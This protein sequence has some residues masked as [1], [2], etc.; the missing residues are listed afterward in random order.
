MK[1]STLSRLV[2]HSYVFMRE[3]HDWHSCEVSVLSIKGVKITVA[4]CCDIC[5]G[6]LASKGSSKR[7]LK[8]W[9]CTEEELW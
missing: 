5:G 3:N 8:T 9:T 4:R 2:G 6:L 7:K 1:T